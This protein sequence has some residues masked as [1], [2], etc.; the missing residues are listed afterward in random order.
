MIREGITPI[1]R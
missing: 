1:G